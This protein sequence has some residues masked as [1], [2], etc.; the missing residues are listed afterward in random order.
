MSP[1]APDLNLMLDLLFLGKTVSNVLRNDGVASS[2]SFGGYVCSNLKR[3]SSDIRWSSRGKTLKAIESTPSSR[4]SSILIRLYFSNRFGPF[5]TSITCLERLT[6]ATRGSLAASS[7][8]LKKKESEHLR[9]NTQHCLYFYQDFASAMRSQSSVINL[10]RN[11]W[12]GFDT[13]PIKIS[14]SHR[15]YPAEFKESYSVKGLIIKRLHRIR[16][17]ATHSS[18]RS[19]DSNQGM[20][21]TSTTKA[22][23]IVVIERLILYTSKYKNRFL[24]LHLTNIETINPA[25][26]API[27]N[28]C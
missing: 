24:D 20:T 28:I 25:P 14:N 15:S 5:D 23:H 7:K 13:C 18:M 9:D 12:V 2:W 22:G 1:T 17:H 26:Y 11:A 21:S 8:Y 10:I 6:S 19:K 27:Y 3:R 16:R 4:F